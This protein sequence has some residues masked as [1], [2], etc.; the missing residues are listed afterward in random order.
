MYLFDFLRCFSA[1]DRDRLRFYYDDVLDPGSSPILIK[2]S[3]LAEYRS[4][5]VGYISYSTDDYLEVYLYAY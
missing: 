4:F 5:S 2:N 1:P 3:D